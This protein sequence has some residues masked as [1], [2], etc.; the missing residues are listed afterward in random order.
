VIKHWESRVRNRAAF[1][2]VELLVVIGIIA[3]MI[4][5][6][7]PA[8]TRARQSALRVACLSNLRQTHQAFF[9]YANM[10]RDQVPMGYRAGQKQF[11]SMIYSATVHQY[12]L[13]GLLYRAQLM[14]PASIF[15]CPAE[16]DEKSML[17][18]AANPWPPGP[19]GDPNIQGYAGYGTRPEVAIPDD[20]STPG[21]T[22]PRLTRF[23]RKAI[24]ADL[25]ALPMRVQTR[26]RSGVN[27]LYGDGSAHWIARPCF[28]ASLAPCASIAAQYNPNQDAIWDSFD[29]N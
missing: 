13:F 12:V 1:T 17:A 8:L 24:F 22:L 15:F 16:T 20:L 9:F 11:N 6:L 3:V 23:K 18:T 25:T 21:T 10:N 29:R 4:G 2:L 27:V 7:L 14:R 26:H 28:D 5:V 19:D